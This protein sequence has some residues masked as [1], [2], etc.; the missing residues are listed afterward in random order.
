MPFAVALNDTAVECEVVMACPGAADEGAAR[1][2]SCCLRRLLADVRRAAAPWA[3][4]P[5]SSRCRTPTLLRERR[6]S[7]AWPVSG[8]QPVKAV[9]VCYR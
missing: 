1:P 4:S 8:S 7:R 3:P 2:D 9:S 6:Q 5:T